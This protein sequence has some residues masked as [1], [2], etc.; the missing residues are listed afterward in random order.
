[1]PYSQH[2]SIKDGE[3]LTCGKP[4]EAYGQHKKYCSMSCRQEA[5]RNRV[6]ERQRGPELRTLIEYYQRSL[7]RATDELAEWE[8]R[9][10]ARIKA[11]SAGEANDNS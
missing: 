6:R 8:R 9:K 1:M 2:G 11:K 4:Y 10:R 7:K 3:C 5:Y